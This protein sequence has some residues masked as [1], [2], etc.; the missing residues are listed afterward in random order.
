MCTL[1]SRFS[2]IRYT[3]PVLQEEVNRVETKYKLMYEKLQAT[4]AELNSLKSKEVGNSVF[5]ICEFVGAAG[6][7]IS[8]SQLL[9]LLE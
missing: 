3:R 5:I 1:H 2:L 8:Y 9:V 4:T 6:S 7:F